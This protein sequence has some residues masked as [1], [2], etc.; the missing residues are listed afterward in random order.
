MEGKRG[1]GCQ[2]PL[3]GNSAVK[4]KKSVTAEKSSCMVKN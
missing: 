4:R 3:L 2:I 1:A